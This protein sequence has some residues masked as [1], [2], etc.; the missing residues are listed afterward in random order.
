LFIHMPF[1]IGL[2]NIHALFSRRPDLIRTH[3]YTSPQALR[4]WFL[5]FAHLFWPAQ[6]LPSN[7]SP[8]G[9]QS[10]DFNPHASPV[11]YPTMHLSL[12]RQLANYGYVSLYKN[13]V[14]A[15]SPAD[16]SPL[17]LPSTITSNFRF[18]YLHTDRSS[19]F[20]NSDIEL[21]FD[22]SQ[23][24]PYARLILTNINKLPTFCKFNSYYLGQL[25]TELLIRILLWT[26]SSCCEH[27]NFPVISTN[28][29]ARIIQ[30]RTNP[31]P[32]SGFP[33]VSHFTLK[34][35]TRSFIPRDT[36]RHLSSSSLNTFTGF[37]FHS[38][39][40]LFTAEDY[41]DPLF[42]RNQVNPETIDMTL[43]D[44]SPSIT[45]TESFSPVNDF[46]IAIQTPPES[47]IGSDSDQTAVTDLSR[48]AS[49]SSSRPSPFVRS[50]PNQSVTNDIPQTPSDDFIFPSP[51]TSSSRASTLSSPSR[52]PLPLTLDD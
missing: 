43:E 26:L 7:F 28:E 44:I 18:E 35:N 51:P 30:L 37:H 19:Y 52:S 8:T 9:F 10:I 15:L 22:L 47:P 41:I 32:D 21:T 45:W 12:A 24:A 34:F 20:L 48:P 16:A 6:I 5:N 49:S 25:P 17:C 38:N 4:L 40:L 27:Q 29:S 11:R 2:M 50:T 14:H 13:V 31:C 33:N 42:P 36:Y 23:I 39:D 3:D 1:L 46:L